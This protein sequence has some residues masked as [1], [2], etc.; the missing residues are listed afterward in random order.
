MLVDFSS[1]KWDTG[2]RQNQRPVIKWLNNIMPDV[3]HR[4][5]EEKVS[6]LSTVYQRCSR[7]F[8]G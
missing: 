3:N 8:V 5:S 6:T 1:K 2:T 7:G 4:P